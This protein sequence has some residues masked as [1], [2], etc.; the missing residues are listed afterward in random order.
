MVT[1]KRIEPNP[2][3]IAAIITMLALKI[4]NDLQLLNGE[5]AALS[6]FL[7]SLQRDPSLY[8]RLSEAN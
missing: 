2:K 4:I 8:S 1:S 7:S 3:K 5:N 6:R